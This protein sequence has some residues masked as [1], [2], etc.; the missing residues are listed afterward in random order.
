MRKN[1]LAAQ[2]AVKRDLTAIALPTRLPLKKTITLLQNLT[3]DALKTGR[4][5]VIEKVCQDQLLA[6]LNVNTEV[7][8][9]KGGRRVQLSAEKVINE[10]MREVMP[11]RLSLEDSGT[12][13]AEGT[14]DYLRAISGIDPTE[15][16]NA[17][18]KQNAIL[19]KG[20][21]KEI[22]DTIRKT[23]I[24]LTNQGVHVEGGTAE[25]ANILLKAGLDPTAVPRLA[26]TIFRTQSAAAY[27][28][29][30]W[31]IV[32]D[33]DTSPHIWGF[34]YCTARDRRVRPEHRLLEG[35]RLPKDDPFWKKYLPPNGWNCR[36]TVL[37]IWKDEDIAKVDFGITGVDPRT[38]T[39]KEL[40]LLPAFAGNV[41]LLATSG[42]DDDN[43]T[44]GVRGKP[45]QPNTPTG[46]RTDVSTK[47]DLPTQKISKQEEIERVLNLDIEARQVIN[48]LVKES[49][50]VQPRIILECIP[51]KQTLKSHQTIYGWE[52]RNGGIK[53]A[54]VIVKNNGKFIV[55][56][57]NRPVIVNGH[58]TDVSTIEKAFRVIREY[59]ARRLKVNRLQVLI[60]WK[61]GAVKWKG[62]RDIERRDK[63]SSTLRNRAKQAFAEAVKEL[64]KGK[65]Q[66]DSII[67]TLK[68]ADGLSF[69][70][71]EIKY[72]W[73]ARLDNGKNVEGLITYKEGIQWIVSYKGRRIEFSEPTAAL[74]SIR[75]V[76]QQTEHKNSSVMWVF[77]YTINAAYKRNATDQLLLSI[78]RGGYIETPI[79]A[80]DND[81]QI[82][83]KMKNSTEAEKEIAKAYRTNHRVYNV[84]KNNYCSIKSP[85]LKI[86]GVY[87]EV[88]TLDI[89]ENLVMRF[90]EENYDKDKI[91]YRI[92]SGVYG[93]VE[94]ANQQDPDTI[95]IYM[96]KS[97]NTL[98]SFGIEI[99]QKE[100]INRMIFYIW[101]KFDSVIPYNFM[102]WYDKDN[103]YLIKMGVYKNGCPEV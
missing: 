53:F 33:P 70:L 21:S 12:V 74:N 31:N 81:A 90:I 7:A 42:G 19:I 47:T 16:N 55:S 20:L 5:E 76:V 61:N 49:E 28:A 88:K 52:F 71:D 73:K 45:T 86:D 82:D 18:R 83:K 32:N 87:Y 23:I 98:K 43:G 77:D 29:G 97:V 38:R 24:D 50:G 6:L 95:I 68:P 66:E 92:A 57:D 67:V 59:A 1:K 37:E 3:Y 102:F 4:T 93:L 72:V 26:E 36:C 48:Q 34:E 58:K 60:K 96:K 80:T 62:Y 15:T 51:F 54:D 91:Y 35:V 40:N 103:K 14:A 84:E 101:D 69:D 100:L 30:R 79:N 25:V 17:F 94:S 78:K 46:E 2:I 41:G 13:Q 8:V 85:D 99:E 89:S 9:L 27:N 56:V 44:A 75:S 63:K 11:V 64:N 22:C 65:R 10:P 39:D